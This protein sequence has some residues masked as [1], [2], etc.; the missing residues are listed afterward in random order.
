MII[1]DTAVRFSTI[2]SIAFLLRIGDLVLVE[3]VFEKTVIS[4][5]SSVFSRFK[6][7]YFFD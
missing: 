7:V 2:I 5:V 6:N 1:T 4:F 3:K